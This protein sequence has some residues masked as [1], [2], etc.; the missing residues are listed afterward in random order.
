MRGGVG[1]NKQARTPDRCWTAPGL[2]SRMLQ[3]QQEVARRGPRT[4][5]EI[6][7]CRPKTAR[8]EFSRVFG[9]RF[10]IN[11]SRT[12]CLRLRPRPGHRHRHH[13]S[14]RAMY[15]QNMQ[16]S[17]IRISDSDADYGNG[18]RIEGSG[19][20]AW[21]SALEARGPGFGVRGHRPRVT[22]HGPRVLPVRCLPFWAPPPPGNC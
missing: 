13:P 14:E 7:I 6:K 1:I 10:C 15:H 11:C 5:E 12:K 2:G 22:G 9:P 3:L 21:Y 17:G 4:K 8:F 20:G 16:I 19:F 18:L